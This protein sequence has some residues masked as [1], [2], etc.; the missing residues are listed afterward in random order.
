[1]KNSY[2]YRF[3][4]D[5]YQELMDDSQYPCET[6][7]PDETSLLTSTKRFS[8]IY[9]RF[10]QHNQCTCIVC[11][12]YVKYK[13]DAGCCS[14]S[15]SI[16]YLQRTGC[17]C[18]LKKSKRVVRRFKRTKSRLETEISVAKKGEVASI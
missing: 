3:D 15:K 9:G 17:K 6:V 1:M 7:P 11:G 8:E 12:Y 2:D 5:A 14:N 16:W 4:F 18:G 13:D 10:V